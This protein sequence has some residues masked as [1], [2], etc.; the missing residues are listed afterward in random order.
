MAAKQV[1]VSDLYNKPECSIHGFVKLSEIQ[2]I[3]P[4]KA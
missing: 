3:G 1:E 4:F 2:V